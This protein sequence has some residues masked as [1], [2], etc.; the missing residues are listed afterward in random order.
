MGVFY[1]AGHG[2]RID[3]SDYIIP[4]DQDQNVS[5][6]TD[7][8]KHGV[9]FSDLLRPVDRI[10]MDSPKRNG[11]VIVYAAAKGQLAQDGIG[12]H[13]PFAESFLKALSQQEFEIFDFYRFISKEVSEITDGKQVPWVSASVDTEFY[14]NRPEVDTNIGLLKILF[15]DSCRD[16]PFKH[17]R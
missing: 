4:I 2:M 15:F 3:G 14:F 9:N 6:E 1:Y 11:A 12:R 5:T 10:I 7:V 17:T 8:L 13:S 16:N